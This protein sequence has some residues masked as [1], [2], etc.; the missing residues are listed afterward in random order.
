[1]TALAVLAVAGA[2]IVG[3]SGYALGATHY[4]A[5]DGDDGR[6]GLTDETA[7]KT[8]T[9]AAGGLERGGPLRLRRGDVCRASGGVAVPGASVAASGPA[10]EAR[11]ASSGSVARAEGQPHADGSYVAETDADLGYLFVNGELMT[12]ARYPNTGWLRTKVWR[13]DDVEDQPG[14]GRGRR[15]R[16]GPRKTFVTCPQLAEHAANAEGYWVGANIRWRHHSWWYETR[17]VIAYDPAGVLTLDDRSFNRTGPFDWDTKGWG[18]YLDGKLDQLDVP[19]EWCLDAEAGKVYLYPPDGL[20]P[21]DSLVEGSLRSRGLTVRDATVRNIAFR[22]QKD[23]GLTID[24]ACTVEHCLFEGIG[25]DATVSE[26]GAGGGALRAERGVLDAQVRHNEF[27]DNLNHSIDWWQDPDAQGSSVIEHNTVVN[28]GTVPGYGGSGSWHAVGI[29]IGSGAD[30]RVRHNRIDGTGYAGILLGSDDNAAEYN[31]IRNAM[32]TL[33]DGAGIYT[34]CSRSTIRNNVILDTKGGMKSSGTWQNISHGIWLEFLRE[35]RESVVEGNTCARS[36]AD[37]IFL[38]NNYECVIRDNVL[39]GNE[40]YPLQLTGRGDG[41]SEDVTQRH[42]I[43]GNV[44]FATQPGERLIYFD[45]RFDYGTLRA[46]YYCSPQTD[47]PFT[48]GK[49]WPGTN[50][51]TGHTLASWQQAYTWADAEAKVMPPQAGEDGTDDLSELFVNDTELPESVLLQGSYQDL[52][53]NTVEGSV[54]LAPYSSRVLIRI[55]HP[56]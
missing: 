18:F 12:I 42:M 7:L 28:S 46:N 38:G 24:G 54:E 50:P 43:E 15:R 47:E 5:G 35:Y 45:P 23:A 31:V 37:G 53:G 6:D 3:L 27:R 30:V 29:L 41:N 36:G 14:E 32:S 2:L 48:E 13:E 52:D 8:V 1:M 51:E 11:P 20:D 16:R 55:D 17:P 4:V 40:R 56:E 49:G 26:R 9:E 39:Y 19:G 34:N 21:N 44:L 25:R 33:N 22:H 10:D